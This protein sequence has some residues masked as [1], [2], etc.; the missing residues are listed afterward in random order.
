MVV[1]SIRSLHYSAIHKQVSGSVSRKPQDEGGLQGQSQHFFSASPAVVLAKKGYMSEGNV[2]KT[3]VNRGLV[4][5][6]SD[7]GIQCL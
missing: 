4:G 3:V 1:M 6:Y 2:V 5:R 7:A